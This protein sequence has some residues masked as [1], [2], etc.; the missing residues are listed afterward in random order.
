[1]DKNK[2]QLMRLKN[3]KE[4]I[5]EMEII[6]EHIEFIRETLSNM[7]D[8][9]NC[10]YEDIEACIKKSNDVIS[11]ANGVIMNDNISCISLI[12]SK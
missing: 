1:M 9:N 6:K 11:Y 7:I 4:L 8:S 3:E 2:K 5:E 10:Y 12:I